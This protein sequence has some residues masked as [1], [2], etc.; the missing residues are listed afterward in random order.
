MFSV[1]GDEFILH[2]SFLLKMTADHPGFQFLRLQSIDIFLTGQ[3][4]DDLFFY[5][6]DKF[7]TFGFIK[8]RIC[9]TIQESLQASPAWEKDR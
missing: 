9:R 1:I 4:Q 6:S 7:P 8:K 2:V 5:N 3:I